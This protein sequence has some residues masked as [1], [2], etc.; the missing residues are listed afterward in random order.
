MCY[1][2]SA[3]T[4]SGPSSCCISAVKDIGGGDKKNV[5]GGDKPTTGI[6]LSGSWV[7]NFTGVSG[8]SYIHELVL[9]RL[10][11]NEW[12]GTRV[13]THLN[14]PLP[15]GK[16]VSDP[17]PGKIVALGGGKAK[18]SFF[19]FEYDVTYTANQIVFHDVT[20]TRK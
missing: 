10:G 20:Y 19:G 5:G 2:I 1:L 7:G 11:A 16:K 4:V 3:V 15:D 18:A 6:D 17:S 13:T 12:Q 9:K 8:C 14:C